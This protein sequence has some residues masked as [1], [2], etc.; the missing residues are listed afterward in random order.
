M[1]EQ[2]RIG[3]QNK[4]R[5]T[6]GVA[7]TAAAA[8]LLSGCRGAREER[9]PNKHTV[10]DAPVTTSVTTTTVVPAPKSHKPPT[11]SAPPE[12]PPFAKLANASGYVRDVERLTPAEQKTYDDYAAQVD[13]SPQAVALMAVTQVCEARVDFA[14]R[15]RAGGGNEGSY[16]ALYDGPEESGRHIFEVARVKAGVT[17][18]A[19]LDFTARLNR[20]CPLPDDVV[21]HGG[22]GGAG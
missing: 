22:L 3:S 9:E 18:P 16:G 14:E 19:E 12:T 20:A 2:G 13:S 8:L 15:I 5:A 7:L 21:P 6:K 10:A 1:G 17:D 4:R 11:A